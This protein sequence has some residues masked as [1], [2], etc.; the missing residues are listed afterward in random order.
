MIPSSVAKDCDIRSDIPRY[1]I[2]EDGVLVDTVENIEHEWKDDSVAFLIGCSYSF[3][4]SLIAAGLM[5]RQYEIGKNVPMYKTSAALCPA[6]RESDTLFF[7][8]DLRLIAISCRIRWQ[9]GGLDETLQARG[10]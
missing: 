6:G 1:N 5:P 4:S 3:E 10:H 8:C 2:Y 7:C 9:N